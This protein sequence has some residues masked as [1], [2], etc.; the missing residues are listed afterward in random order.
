[1]R[2]I[3]LQKLTL[4]LS[5]LGVAAYMGICAA[6]VARAQSNISGDIVGTVTDSSGAVLPNAKVTV[7]SAASGQAKVVV[8][9]KAGD[10][11]VPLLEP[12]SY[13]ISVT[14]PGFKTT[15][16]TTTVS[17]GAISK[18]SIQLGVGPAA[19]TVEVTETQTMLLHTD[20]ADL[21]TMITP[22]QVLTLPNPG[23]DM[24]FVAQ[25]APGSIMNTQG[26]YGNFSS[27]G[28]PATANTFSLNGGYEN[29]PFLNVNNSGATNLLLGN[30]DVSSVSVINNGYDASF[31]G[32]GGAQVNEISRSGSNQFH[33]NAT[34]FWN[35]RL[36]NAN[37]WFNKHV[38][39]PADVTPR[40]FDNANQWAAGVGGPIKRDKTHFF[41]DYEGLR[42]ILPT[43]GTVYAPSPAYQTAVLG[44]SIC[45]AYNAA[46]G[47]KF[48]TTWVD[49]NS[50]TIVEPAM[51]ACASA[52]VGTTGIPGYTLAPYG[53]LAY[54]GNSAEA[55]LY[56]TIFAFYNK[57]TGPTA[58]SDPNVVDYN[59][60]AS[61]FTHEYQIAGRVDQT[62]GSKDSLFG[63]V[64]VD[65]GLQATS[66]S[67][68]NP[69][70]DAFSPQPQ[71]EGQLGETHTFT[72]NL[73]N[74]FLFANIY[75]RAVFT[76]TTQAQA[77]AAVPFTLVFLN[78]SLANDG[79]A[80]LVGGADY[81]WPQG[82]DVEGY[83]FQD[84]V[85]WTKGKHTIKVGWTMRRDDI[86]D[87][88]PGVRAVTPEAYGTE[89]SLAAGFATRFRQSFP[90]QTKQPIALYT[91]GMYGQDQWK[92]A[93]NLTATFGL[94]IEHNSNPI[95]TV[96]CFALLTSNFASVASST[97]TST[98]YNKMINTGQHAALTSYQGIG[99]E[100][101]L[102]I[103]WLPFGA[104]S[105]TTV[106]T[107]FG[108]FADAFPGQV[109]DELLSNA[110]TSVAF[111]LKTAAASVA[112]P[113]G[114]FILQSSLAGSGSQAVSA[115]NTAFQAGFKGGSSY[116]SL[117]ASV[118]GFAAPG[119]TN[120]G[121]SVKYPTYEEWN[122]TIEQQ[123]NPTT[124]LSVG[125]VGN[126]SYH[127]P[128]LNSGVNA[129]GFGSLPAA[130]PSNSFAQVTEIGSGANSND[131]TLT[132]SLVR[133]GKSVTLQF[134]Y[135]WSHALDEISNGGFNPF[136]DS[137]IVSPLAPEN[138]FNLRQNY[139]NAD[140]DVRQY[141]SASYVINV[142]YWRGPK[143][144]VD[145]WSLGGTVFHSTGLPFTMIDSS[146][147]LNYGGSLYADQLDNK[148]NHHCGGGAAVD[149]PC[150]FAAAG[151]SSEG[152]AHFDN[153]T[154]FGQQ[155]RNQLTGSGYTDTDLDL[156]KGFG[157]PKWES[158]KVKIGA[159]FFNLFNHP[160]FGQPTND[161]E[162]GFGGVGT[163]NAM[164]S[165]PTSIL[166]SFLGGDASP[167]L[168]QA[169][170]SF[171][172]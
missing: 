71:Y 151:S 15:T 16:E 33:G 170:L 79:V 49:S 74:Q 161:V 92:L 147:P 32:L 57:L 50:N 42:V 39:N 58:D 69:E 56:Q 124:A 93:A 157:I 112:Y 113:R 153:A 76:N 120:P 168:V 21:S 95:C 107:G 36:L 38:S 80:G 160:N 167:R 141:V 146:S 81:D 119:F 150:A 63:H 44:P 148:F 136:Q 6:T 47:H 159:Q 138:P 53:N 84:D 126:H 97:S 109:A 35:G 83:Q 27:F 25:T 73:T 115:S 117:A 3:R 155:R 88:D 11:R 156:Q 111:Y 94:R 13:S 78:G 62:L 45:P 125:Y 30:N 48:G 2:M 1:M 171:V 106:R 61:N 31:G 129:F 55:S 100:P 154:N 135:Q 59:G 26:G 169:K 17:T 43:R 54:W 145:G 37:D 123:L 165:T 86:T 105:H 99:F 90:L 172:F 152:L 85:S 68:L 134:N 144:L 41:V 164:V 103:A 158:G 19:T 7:T 40:S 116:T 102:G 162:G 46:D 122:L 5:L 108:M 18:I 140:Y 64:T 23:N 114:N 4:A 142:P 89:G 87:Y 82:R 9:D 12:G 133:R 127:Q 52:L 66:T 137:D 75:Y 163:I 104:N 8:S 166:G 10:F 65:K 128:V 60:T 132:T 24:T 130:A 96:G 77:N 67:L 101:R 139:G 28:L 121:S 70:F 149:T 110:P 29:D 143:I 72:Q 20:S 98:A 118:P 14:A 51:P 22:E 91:M 34:Y 131:N